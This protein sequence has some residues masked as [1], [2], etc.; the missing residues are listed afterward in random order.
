MVVKEEICS[1]YSAEVSVGGHRGGAGVNPD[2]NSITE[3]PGILLIGLR[4]VGGET[5]MS[6][7]IIIQCLDNLR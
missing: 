7:K 1:D 5:D 6:D 4:D 2:M 3:A